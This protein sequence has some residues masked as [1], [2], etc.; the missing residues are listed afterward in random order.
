MT[1]EILAVPT[2]GIETH[3]DIDAVYLSGPMTGLPYYNYPAFFAAAAAL[4]DAGYRTYNPAASHGLDA[5]ACPTGTEK[6]EGFDARAAFAEYAAFITGRADAV[7]VL[8]GWEKSK[9]ARAEVALASAIDLPIIC[10]L[11][12]EVIE[13][14]I[15]AERIEDEAARAACMD[16]HPAGSRRPSIPI[17]T[18]VPDPEPAAESVVTTPRPTPRG[19]GEVRTVSRTGGQKGVKEAQASLIPP[20]PLGELAVLFSRAATAKYKDG[21]DGSPNWKRGFNWSLSYD[22]L[23]RHLDAWWSRTEDHDP[24]MGVKHIICVAWHA[25][26]LAWFME[27]RPDFDDRPNGVDGAGE[28]Y[29]GALPTPQWI[30]D[31]VQA[32]DE[33]TGA[34]PAAT[35][36]EQ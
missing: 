2:T 13:V 36:S 11:T 17:L 14:D 35:G 32:S 8:P 15:Y 29:T 22:S 20:G 34:V 18:A 5:S 21:P 1:T 24:E 31:I 23:R 27:N 30:L 12:G 16:R 10:A 6:V 7:A 33:S 19:G 4:N 3:A 25:F 26:V 9:G 28:T